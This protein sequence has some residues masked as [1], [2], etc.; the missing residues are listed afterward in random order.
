[1]ET[2]AAS[3]PANPSSSPANS[4][5]AISCQT[6]SS[7]WTIA[8]ARRSR[9]EVRAAQKAAR[10]DRASPRA[11]A[12]CLLNHVVSLWFVHAPAFVKNGEYRATKSVRLVHDV[13]V[14]LLNS[15]YVKMEEVSSYKVLSNASVFFFF[16]FSFLKRPVRFS[17]KFC[18]TSL[19]P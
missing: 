4:D 18:F 19:G 14:A 11:W 7:S 16:F 1:M 5:A 8:L 15:D 12:K 13:L 17:L 3:S 10:V 2:P 6:V 9:Q